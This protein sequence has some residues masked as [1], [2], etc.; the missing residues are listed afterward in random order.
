MIEFDPTQDHA[1]HRDAA[2]NVSYT[3]NGRNFQAGGRLVDPETDPEKK[4]SRKQEIRDRAD[5][6]LAGFRNDDAPGPIEK[7][8]KE[9]QAAEAAE[10]NAE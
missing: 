5:K 2:G 6:K 10:A 4:A 8:L 9:N 1:K 7:A 3:Q